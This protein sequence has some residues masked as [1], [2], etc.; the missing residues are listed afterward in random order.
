[1]THRVLNKHKVRSIIHISG[2]HEENPMR[3]SFSSSQWLY[4][5]YKREVL[6]SEAKAFMKLFKAI[7]YPSMKIQTLL[8][9]PK[10]RKK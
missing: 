3:P 2:S 9:Y 4:S 5:S 8:S 10:H 6:F 7:S 1:M